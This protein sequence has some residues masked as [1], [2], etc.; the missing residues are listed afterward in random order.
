[1]EAS[2]LVFFK[3]MGQ[4]CFSY[5]MKRYKNL[6]FFRDLKKKWVND[7]YTSK[8]VQMF[9]AAVA[10]AKAVFEFPEKVIYE[11]LED[12]INRDEVFRWILE[13]T[14]TE[15]Y[16]SQNLNLETYMEKY[17]E[18]QD[19]ISPFFEMINIELQE[20]KKIHWDPEFLQILNQIRF[21]EVG[22]KEDFEEIKRQQRQVVSLSE[23]NNYLLKA[24]LEPVGFND[25]N[26][27]IKNGKIIEARQKAEE[28]LNRTPLNREDLIELNAVIASS[29][30]NS[31]QE[32]E[33]IPFL[34]VAS[35]HCQESAR[36]KRLMAIVDLLQNRTESAAKNINNAI[37]IEGKTAKNVE[38]LANIYL[39]QGMFD[40]AL[41]VLDDCEDE[42][43]QNSI[44]KGYVLLAQKKYVE[45][46]SL[47]EQH[48]K[49]DTFNINW[50]M[51]KVEA[52]IFE[53]ES[54]ISNN[55]IVDT[56][57]LVKKVMY[58]IGKI[59]MNEIENIAVQSR[60]KEMK[61][62]LFFRNKQFSEAKLYYEALYREKN[63]TQSQHFKNYLW[64]CLCDEDFEKAI[65]LLE[66][67]VKVDSPNKDDITDL[68]KVY[69]DA[70]RPQD[71]ISL[72][73][74]NRSFFNNE[75][76]LPL[77]YYIPL[78]E[79]FFLSLQYDDANRL[80][81]E[82]EI[83]TTDK[84]GISALKAYY[85]SQLHDW[86]KA[87]EKWEECI[88]F[89]DAEVL[90]E[91]KIQLS[92]AYL[93]RGTNEDLNKLKLLVTSIPNWKYHEP[94]V[95]RYVHAL[96][97]LGEYKQV[98]SL[99]KELP[100]INT[101]IMDV[102]ATIYFNLGWFETAKENFNSLYLK[103]K[104]LNY[105][106]KYANCLFRLGDNQECLIILEA[107]ENRVRKNGSIEDYNLLSVAYMNAMQYEKSLEFAY[108]TYLAGKGHPDAWKFYFVQMSQLNRF[109]ENTKEEWSVEYRYIIDN[110]HVKFPDEEPIFRQLKAIE[111]DGEIA[112]EL[113][114]E[115]KKS[116]ETTKY[117]LNYYTEQKLPMSFLVAFLRKQPFEIWNHIVNVKLSIWAIRGLNQELETNLFVAKGSV[118]VLIDLTTLYTIRHLGLLDKLK[119]KYDL[120]IHQE[121]V[122]RAFQE[123]LDAKLMTED[124]Q[125][126]MYYENGRVS[127]REYSPEQLKGTFD[128]QEEFIKWI[129]KNCKKLG[130]VIRDRIIEKNQFEFL[131]NPIET[132]KENS[133]SILVDSFLTIAYAKDG[134]GVDG[135]TTFD[136][137]KVLYVEKH[138]SK[139]E[140]SEAIGK[141]VF[142]GY[143]LIPVDH[144]IFAFYLNKH[145]F[146]LHNEV[147]TLFDY[148]KREEFSEKYLIDLV[149]TL[150]GWIW[151]EA[152]PDE[153][154]RRLTDYLCYVLTY[155]RNKKVVINTLIEHSKSKFS[156][157]VQHQWEKMNTCIQQWIR[158]QVI[159]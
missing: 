16:S 140:Y 17:P 33:A 87:I 86:D 18:F 129:N 20:Y 111:E 5:A 75:K 36:K 153:D 64:C 105:L 80:I 8:T 121:D 37:D 60:I 68:A 13:G 84:V 54:E 82:A 147:I 63:D 45:V 71:A 130:N 92:L 118:G 46:I 124:G 149:G 98:I 1:M 59:E 107:A 90:I 38:V 135:F 3:K 89:L 65:S 102:I 24:V 51:L 34:L 77:S 50:I 99:S 159:I 123:Y 2:S 21:L 131:N 53:M 136:L 11:L 127:F 101:F 115:L 28:R 152:I 143:S 26:K 58:L 119:A 113:I 48:I 146:K 110:F 23:E 114:N 93:N 155:K 95:N 141:L 61:G 112:E 151:I 25:L 76:H 31:N 85:F 29:Y 69:V 106:L 79:A 66:S 67:R 116:T 40:L 73:E 7:N 145:I 125:K 88:D 72:L 6:K 157:L 156:P 27:L 109:V 39:K 74:E 55:H 94:L 83:I 15:L 150:L 43:G 70:G 35:S 137:L 62:A 78:I 138:I 139:T 96:F 120:Y 128:E 132:C 142:I 9:E 103:T 56:E 100:E 122:D 32:E 104:E 52:L 81:D 158:T 12:K 42:E 57:S 10:D 97:Q 126:L 91:N 41:E 19:T 154:R 22:I 144:D 47:S 108:E 133:L 49:K 134:F 14:P 4:L 44:L 30:I 148:L 117:Y